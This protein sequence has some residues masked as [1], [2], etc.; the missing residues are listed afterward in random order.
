[1]QHTLTQ[2]QSATFKRHKAQ[3]H[4]EVGMVLIVLGTVFML[5]KLNVLT[6]ELHWYLL[7]AVAYATIGLVKILRFKNMNKVFSGL[8]DIAIGAW[9]YISFSGLW[10]MS[11][12]NSWPILLIIVGAGL[13]AK[14][15]FKT[16]NNNP[17]AQQEEH[18][19]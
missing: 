1:M 17:C 2:K 13:V 7:A 18:K 4:I 11:P 5:S 12:A 9:F 14:S 10:G 8:S 6:L 16:N 19:Q 3:G 15:L